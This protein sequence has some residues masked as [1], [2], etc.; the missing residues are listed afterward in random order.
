MD[1][2][3]WLLSEA[4]RWKEE[5]IITVEQYQQIAD[6]YPPVR[7]AGTLPVMGGILL[8]LGVLTFIASNWDGMSHMT[9]LVLILASM[10]V[11]YLV[12]DHLKQTDRERLG[13]AFLVVGV[14]IYGA[15]FFLIGQMY[16][17]SANP[18][19]AF[20]LWYAGAV[21]LAWHY[22]SQ[23]LAFV[24]LLILSA[25]TLYGVGTDS[26]EGEA[27]LILYVLY[28]AGLL[29]LLWEWRKGWLSAVFW[30]VLLGTAVLDAIDYTNGLLVQLPIFTYLLVSLL[31]P[32]QAEPIQSQLRIVSYMSVTLFA[33][34]V[35]F[36][37]D[38][39]L[40]QGAADTS[41]AAAVL[42]AAALFLVAACRKGMLSQ[43]TDLLPHLPLPL[44][45]LLFAGQD[46]SMQPPIGLDVAMILAL[47]TFA[48]G[49]VLS[50]EKWHDV[51]RLNTGAVLFGV[52]SF[53]AYV[54]FA[55]DFM[56][57]SLFFLI[58]GAL[59]LLL[60]FILERQRRRWV[61][62]ARRERR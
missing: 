41:G 31:L 51:T 26:R 52:T 8:G 56:D 27:K 46:G 2:R 18:L 1:K 33:V 43:A 22:R 36:F 16:H 44:Y 23:T 4:E 48:I 54:N 11:V 7:R 5:G 47:Y 58:G 10:I 6:R 35:I 17:L 55:W 19:T 61:E 38:F 13:M 53:V 37:G 57:K 59:L 29:P 40:K 39:A 32:K 3:K 60:S 20:Y 45:Y 12:G 15:G 9:R 25:A 62:Q 21:T 42:F 50:G 30:V 24:S 28:A 14:A 34:F 49:M